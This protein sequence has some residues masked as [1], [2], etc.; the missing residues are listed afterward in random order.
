METMEVSGLNDVFDAVIAFVGVLSPDG[1]IVE[2][3]QPARK[4]TGVAHDDIAGVIFWDAPWFA[5]DPALVDRVRTACER[6]AAGDTVRFDADV[7]VA[8]GQPMTID[9]QIAPQRNAQGRVTALVPSATDISDRRRTEIALENAHDTF[10]TVVRSSP[11][12]VV[13]IDADLVLRFMSD[14]ARRAFDV[15]HDELIGRNYGEI[16]HAAWPDAVARTIVAQL[17]SVLET[18]RSHHSDDL[19]DTRRDRAVVE[20]YEWRADRIFMPDRRYGVVC[21]FYDLSER[22]HYEAAI[23][24]SEELFRSTFENAAVGM[25]HV[26]PDGS[27]LRVNQCLCEMLGYSKQEMI[28]LRFQDVT[29]PE[30]LVTDLDKLAGLLHG[31]YNEYTIQKRYLRRDGQVVW[32][33][34]TVGCVRRADGTVDYLISV[35]QDITRQKEA[36]AQRDLLVDELNHRVKNLLATIQSV[37]SHTRRSSRDPDDFHERFTGR[38]QAISRAHDSI[39]DN[40]AGTTTLR[41]IIEGQFEIYYPKGSRRVTCTGPR[42]RLGAGPAGNVGIIV[43]ELLTNAIKYGALSTEDGQVAIDWTAAREPGETMITMTWTEAGGPP[44][45]EPETTG[46][47]SA[48]IRI[49]LTQSLKGELHTDFAP[50]GLVVT[51]SLRV[52]NNGGRKSGTS[53]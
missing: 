22:A 53:G 20:T 37:S 47:G 30:D 52:E 41:E 4:A 6:A 21:H 18:G 3:N 38:L 19:T 28:S 9:F 8:G 39:F 10:A 14:G 29:H 32:A 17:R 48:L 51:M 23:R 11:F 16:M 40:D 12:G 31:D 33:T 7:R 50:T 35:L 15:E 44:V 46:F 24:E 2:I 25:A 27:W 49:M 36:E 5:H 34:L 1:R 45:T 26:G 43:H 42:V 13:V